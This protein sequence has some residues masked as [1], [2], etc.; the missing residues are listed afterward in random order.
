MT[1][2]GLMASVQPGGSMSDTARTPGLP[3]GAGADESQ[4]LQARF[5]QEN[6]RRIFLQIY[7]I[8]GN[9]DDAQDLTQETF[10]KA[11]QRREQIKDLD[12]AA[13]WLSR[14]ATNTAIDFL[15]R[16]GRLSFTE[17]S[18]LAEPLSTEPERSPE[19]LVLQAEGSAVLR[20]GLLQ[21]S[22]RERTAI[23]LRDVDGLP[24]SEVAQVL[25]CS[26]ATV[27]SHIANA[28]MKFRRFL[29]RRKP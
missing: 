21:L 6:L 11:L 1:I 8:I 17:I 25:Q 15:R 18:S 23:M 20:E 16:H 10:I 19:A 9:I 4:E 26:E 2:A 12:K 22:E 29:E 5:V 14:I 28:R 13:H 3:A 27:R 24:S 7:R